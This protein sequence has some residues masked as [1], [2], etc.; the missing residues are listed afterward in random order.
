MFRSVLCRFRRPRAASETIL[1]MA[2][3]T[4]EVYNTFLDASPLAVC[5]LIPIFLTISE[6]CS[7]G[8]SRNIDPI[9]MSNVQSWF[10]IPIAKLPDGG[11]PPLAATRGSC[12]KTRALVKRT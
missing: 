1:W 5:S 8:S 11:R 10:L 9:R 12:F 7:P 3:V 4:F 6:G 2:H